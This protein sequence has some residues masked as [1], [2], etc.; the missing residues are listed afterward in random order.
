MYYCSNVYGQLNLEPQRLTSTKKVNSI[1]HAQWHS[2][3]Y[4]L[5]KEDKI[6]AEMDAA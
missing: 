2:D 4:S 5:G 1:A 6:Q 3:L